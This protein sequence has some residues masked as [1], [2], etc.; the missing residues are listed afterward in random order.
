MGIVCE[1]CR[2]A[3]GSYGNITCYNCCDLGGRFQYRVVIDILITVFR[4]LP[5]VQRISLNQL[6]QSWRHT[7]GSWAGAGQDDL[8]EYS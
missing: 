1:W 6:S 8:S 4:S 7:T 3:A 5:S 2:C